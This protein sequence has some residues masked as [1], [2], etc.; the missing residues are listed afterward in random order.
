MKCNF[1]LCV[2]L[3]IRTIHSCF[4]I[5]LRASCCNIDYGLMSLRVA[6]NNKLSHAKVLI[7]NGEAD[8][9]R[10]TRSLYFL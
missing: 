10:F 7:A 4:L 9:V 6:L 1:W 8:K 2:A 5:T 3:Q